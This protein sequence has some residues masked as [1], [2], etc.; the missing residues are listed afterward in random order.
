MRHYRIILLLTALL[1]SLSCGKGPQT[2]GVS[3][4]PAFRSFISPDTKVLASIQLDRLKDSPLYGRHEKELDLTRLDAITERIGVD[5]RRDVSEV[6][7]AWNGTRSLV[8]ARGHFTPAEV[9]RKLTALGGQPTRYK[10]YTLI[11]NKRDSVVFLSKALAAAGPS[12]LLHAALQ[13]HD[14]GSGAVPEELR[15]RLR[16]I[17]SQ[18]QIWIVSRGGLPFAEIPM[19][20]DIESALSN[21]VSYVNG[22]NTG[23]GID[24][25]VHLQSDITCISDQG[26]QRV[27]DALRGGIGLARLSTKDDES[28]L[29]RLYDTINVTR[30]QQTV[31]VRA[32][33]PGELAD[34]LFAYLPQLTYRA[35]QVLKER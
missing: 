12:E 20:S 23:V 11:G 2:T 6:L 17:P 25:G 29:L 4:D 35:S 32:D 19:R 28:D 21:I 13:N 31:H 5:P 10:A 27:H 30:D 14:S 26:A 22:T 16:S 34:K 24:S 15:E 8:L 3:V 7:V 1:A 18:D 9:Q 33:I